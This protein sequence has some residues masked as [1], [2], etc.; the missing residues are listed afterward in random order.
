MLTIRR[1]E[2]KNVFVVISMIKSNFFNA[3]EPRFGTI[4]NASKQNKL[5]EQSLAQA[6]RPLS[7]SIHSGMCVQQRAIPR[8]KIVH[9]GGVRH[10]TVL[11]AV[12]RLP[13]SSLSRWPQISRAFDTVDLHIV[14]SDNF[15]QT[16]EYIV[17]FA[18]RIYLRCVRGCYKQ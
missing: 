15:Q 16:S 4:T 8:Y 5:L 6:N 7:D 12:R 2:V 11:L 1:V 14:I 17:H 9:L 18:A 13:K 10:S 3:H